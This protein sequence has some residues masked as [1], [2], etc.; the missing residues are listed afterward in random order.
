MRIIGRLDIKGQN[1]IISGGGMYNKVLIQ[2][3]KNELSRRKNVRPK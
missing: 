2:D 3:I 1:L